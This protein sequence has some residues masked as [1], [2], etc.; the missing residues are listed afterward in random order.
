MG[1]RAEK[2]VYWPGFLSDIE[3]KWSD[4]STCHRIAQAQA[5]LPPVELVVP[6]Y[7]FVWICINDMSL[8][9]SGYMCLGILG[10]C[11]RTKGF[12]VVRLL[13]NLCKDYG[14]PV[15]VTLNGGQNL[16]CKEFED[17]MWD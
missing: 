1:M 4:C 13:T 17:L 2:S 14:V 11:K 10:V 7:P 12:N 9:G 3:M 16:V 5:K 15:S 6:K 8:N